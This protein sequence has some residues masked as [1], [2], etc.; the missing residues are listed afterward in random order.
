MLQCYEVDGWE[1]RDD[2]NCLQVLVYCHH[3]DWDRKDSFDLSLALKNL[4]MEGQV[5]I[6]HY[7]IDREHSN[8]CT[9]WERQ[10][11]PDWPDD[12]QRA[13]IL[14]R[15]GLELLQKPEKA[16]VHDG[17]M[18]IGFS[19]PIHGISLLEIRGN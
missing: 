7:R 15:S 16:D 8:A 18:E 6:T 10:G 3:D 4:P 14:A 17:K 5:C 9:E 19:L 1:V 2:E 12:E 13:A 11:K